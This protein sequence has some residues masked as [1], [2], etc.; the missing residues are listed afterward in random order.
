MEQLTPEQKFGKDVPFAD[1]VVRCDGCRNLIFATKLRTSGK[2]PHCGNRKVREIR[3]LTE[4]EYM[5][6]K[7]SDID[8]DFLK[9]FEPETDDEPEGANL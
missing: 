9:M 4:S 6:L 3:H 7:S 5:V 1:P 2:C 8:P